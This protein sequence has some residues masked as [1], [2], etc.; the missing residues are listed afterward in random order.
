[1]LGRHLRVGGEVFFDVLAGLRGAVV[2]FVRQGGD[3][4]AGDVVG[5]AGNL[6]H[7][8]VQLSLTVLASRVLTYQ[9]P[10]SVLWPSAEQA[11]EQLYIVSARWT[12]SMSLSLMC[13]A[14]GTPLYSA[15]EAV[16]PMM[17]SATPTLQPP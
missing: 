3:E 2:G 14:P 11:I 1:V 5:E 6:V 7:V 8:A 4:A 9:L 10:A 12:I 17:T 15:I 13:E 16:A